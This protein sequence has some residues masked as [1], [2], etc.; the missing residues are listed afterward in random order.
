[1]ISHSLRKIPLIFY[2]SGVTWKTTLK[3]LLS[4]YRECSNFLFPDKFQGLNYNNESFPLEDSVLNVYV[5]SLH[6]LPVVPLNHYFSF[7]FDIIATPDLRCIDDLVSFIE[8]KMETGFLDVK[9]E[10]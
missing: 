10:V 5:R 6:G 4:S 7:P 3:D 2:V 8:V 9:F 1:M